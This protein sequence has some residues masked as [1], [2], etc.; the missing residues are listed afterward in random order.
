MFYIFFIYLYENLISKLK[1]KKFQYSNKK[2]K[3]K[4][5]HISKKMKKYMK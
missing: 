4:F 5:V 2:V 1:K 3:N